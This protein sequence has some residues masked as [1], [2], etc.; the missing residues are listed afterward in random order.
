[1]NSCRY[2]FLWEEILQEKRKLRIG[3]CLWHADA[4][5]A[6]EGEK[7]YSLSIFTILHPVGRPPVGSAKKDR[8][9]F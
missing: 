2:W 6:D 3:N 4:A 5:Q 9:R 7:V 8:G 1:M